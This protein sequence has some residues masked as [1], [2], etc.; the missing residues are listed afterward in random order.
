M[1]YINEFNAR[2]DRSYTLKM[3]KFGDLS[4]EEFV[5]KYVKSNVGTIAGSMTTNPSYQALPVSF[6]WR[7]KNIVPPV[8]DLP[9]SCGDVLA[10]V[11]L[12]LAETVCAINSSH[13]VQL[14]LQQLIDCSSACN[15]GSFDTTFKYLKTYGLE[16]A[17]SYPDTQTSGP[18]KYNA[19]EVVCKPSNISQVPTG[20]ETA[21][22]VDLIQY[23]PLIA[24]IDA[25]HGSFQFYDGGVYYQSAC[26]A[27]DIDMAILVVGYGVLNNQDYWICENAW[28]TAWGLDGYILMSRNRNNNCGI[29]TDTYYAEV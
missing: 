10:I 2:K 24:G 1:A 26:S 6:D 23:G 3:N 7:E 9:S 5:S 14:S 22:A 11:G 27:T 16:S 4:H 20:N 12:E 28:G 21:M 13:Y 25:S 15:G 18:C 17:A 29:A 19:S 8:M